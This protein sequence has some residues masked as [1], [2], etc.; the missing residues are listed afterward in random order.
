[1]PSFT[2]Y[3]LCLASLQRDEIHHT[4]LRAIASSDEV[5]NA[6]GGSLPMRIIA[7]MSLHRAVLTIF[8][9]GSRDRQSRLKMI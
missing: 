2:E 6:T 8:M 4:V 9:T 3:E 7:L 5:S 1:M